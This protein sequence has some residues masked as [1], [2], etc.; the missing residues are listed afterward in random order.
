MRSNTTT[1]LEFRRAD[2]KLEKSQGGDG[3]PDAVV[4]A[5]D[6]TAA[7]GDP[8]HESTSGSAEAAEASSENRQRWTP[9]KS[10]APARARAGD[11]ATRESTAGSGVRTLVREASPA[12]KQVTTPPCAATREAGCGGEGHSAT[13]EGAARPV[14]GRSAEGRSESGA[15]AEAGEREARR[16]PSSA[17]WRASARSAAEG[18]DGARRRPWRRKERR[19]VKRRGSPSRKCGAE[20]E[21][22]AREASGEEAPARESVAVVVWK[23]S[24]PTL[25]ETTAAAEAMDWLG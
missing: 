1:A 25:R 16:A 2:S 8:G 24:P 9:G 5:I 21:E 3:A 15:K 20:G 11:T 7:E 14:S 13:A 23:S 18:G 22:G 12:S 10:R 4:V 17:K 19:W 6:S